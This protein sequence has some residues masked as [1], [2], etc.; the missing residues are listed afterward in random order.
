M[1]ALADPYDILREFNDLCRTAEADATAGVGL[2]AARGGAPDTASPE[3]TT[4]GTFLLPRDTLSA[5]VVRGRL[6]AR[7][8]ACLRTLYGP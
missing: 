5:F 8:P 4:A 2:G 7:P 3:T 1:V 6:P